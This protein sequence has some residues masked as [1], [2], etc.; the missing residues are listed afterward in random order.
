[1]AKSDAQRLDR[2]IDQL[3]AK[4]PDRLGK[5]VRWLRSPPAPWVRI[6]IALLLIAG[7]LA[8]FLPL[9]GFWM[10]PLGLLLLALDVPFLRRPILRCIT[11]LQWRWARL[12]A[13]WRRRR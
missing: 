2:K 6:P 7:G 3:A 10:V 5:T 11:W 8:G 13:W 12:R 1:V 9:L 4:L